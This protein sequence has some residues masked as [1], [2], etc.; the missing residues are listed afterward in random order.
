[1]DYY[2]YTTMHDAAI[3]TLYVLYYLATLN[4]LHLPYRDRVPTEEK[5]MYSM[6]SMQM[7]GLK[8][9]G[10]IWLPKPSLC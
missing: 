6:H 2:V 4:P 8:S 10:D 9:L 5:H 3:C 1:M 7:L